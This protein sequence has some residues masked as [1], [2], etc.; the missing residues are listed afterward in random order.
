MSCYDER[1]SRELNYSTDLVRLAN[2]ELSGFK[3]TNRCHSWPSNCHLVL[4]LR[5]NINNACR[6]IQQ[7]DNFLWEIIANPNV[8]KFGV[9]SQ[10]MNR[11]GT[12]KAPPN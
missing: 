12:L 6:W 4:G 11:G 5:N 8:A 2:L 9:G 1:S 7:H 3:E 10:I